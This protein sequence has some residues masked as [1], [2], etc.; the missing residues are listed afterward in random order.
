MCLRLC[1]IIFEDKR[2]ELTDAQRSTFKDSK[3]KDYKV[4]FYIQES[5]KI[6]KKHKSH[7]DQ[8]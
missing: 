2:A 1:K 7:I 8:R 5:V 6:E 4:L 3:K